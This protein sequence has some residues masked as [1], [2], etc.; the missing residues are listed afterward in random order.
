[1]VVKWAALGSGA[2]FLYIR[3]EW[4]YFRVKKLVHSLVQ[5]ENESTPGVST[6]QFSAIEAII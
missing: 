2:G 6:M 5:Q 4:V 3:C 1:M